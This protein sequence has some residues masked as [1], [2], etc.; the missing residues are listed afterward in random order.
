M[1]S[2]HLLSG[3]GISLAV[4]DRERFTNIYACMIIL[5]IL[6]K[7]RDEETF[8]HR[9]FH[10]TSFLA[11]FNVTLV[12]L[13]YPLTTTLTMY[14]CIFL[15]AI[16]SLKCLYNVYILY[17]KRLM[18]DLVCMSQSNYAMIKC[19]VAVRKFYDLMSILKLRILVSFEDGI[20]YINGYESP[21]SNLYHFSKFFLY[22]RFSNSSL[23]FLFLN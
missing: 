9:V 19:L 6:E 23:H 15:G 7:R 11:H 17:L 4:T 14:Y 20:L 21:I 13:A 5:T 2:L 8:L 22:Y 10:Q 3:Y 16:A 1:V 18:Q 12:F